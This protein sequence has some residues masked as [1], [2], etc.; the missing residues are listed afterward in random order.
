M[1]GII[2]NW[3]ISMKKLPFLMFFVICGSILFAQTT[4]GRDMINGM[5][6]PIPENAWGGDWVSADGIRIYALDVEGP[7]SMQKQWFVQYGRTV[8]YVHHISYYNA[9]DAEQAATTL[10]N[11]FTREFGDAT[12]MGTELIWLTS[13]FKYRITLKTSLNG[14]NNNNSVNVEIQHL[15]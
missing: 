8:V 4:T 12:R 5:E 1:I 13:D 7:P 9:S 14:Q 10:V 15:F 3:R 6:R 11:G 2:C